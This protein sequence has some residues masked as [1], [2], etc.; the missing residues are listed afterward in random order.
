LD[1]VTEMIY[2]SD[3]QLMFISCTILYSGL[4]VLKVPILGYVT[5]Y[6]LIEYDQFWILCSP[7]WWLSCRH[8]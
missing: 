8:V 6:F 4:C 1:A 5:V 3:I 2:C 7:L